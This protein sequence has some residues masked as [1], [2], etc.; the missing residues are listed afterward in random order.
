M[1]IFTYV[2]NFQVQEN[3]NSSETYALKIL[4]KQHIVA[5]GQQTQVQN[6]KNI[7]AEL[8]SDFIVR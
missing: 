7:M 2:T 8:R 3:N 4:S 5:I 6:E 1:Y